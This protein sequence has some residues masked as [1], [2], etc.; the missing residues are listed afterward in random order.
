M[1]EKVK[2]VEISLQLQKDEIG[3]FAKILDK[4]VIFENKRV[5]SYM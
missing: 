2:Q 3:F 1:E 4:A 5:T